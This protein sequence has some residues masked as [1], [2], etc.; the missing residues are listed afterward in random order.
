MKKHECPQQG[1]KKKHTASKE[2]GR[3]KLKNKS[4]LTAAEVLRARKKDVCTI[5][6][7]G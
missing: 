2:F 4:R 3:G 7:W 1:G 5:R 6:L